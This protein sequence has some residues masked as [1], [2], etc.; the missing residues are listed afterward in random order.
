MCT[1]LRAGS[2]SIFP[3]SNFYL[4]PLSFYT[5]AQIV[6]A[7]RGE[8]QPAAIRNLIELISEAERTYPSDEQRPFNVTMRI[9][10]RFVRT[11]GQEA[12][13]VR[14][15]RDPEAPAVQLREEDIRQAYP[16]DYG[17]L[18]ERLKQ[19]YSDFL[20]NQRYHEIRQRLEHD[21]RLCRIRY[22]DPANPGRSA[23]KRYYSP[24]IIA[25]FDPHYTRR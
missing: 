18:T 4:M 6:E 2:A 5:P 16:W 22:L 1:L 15:V 20:Q 7:L 9:D 14:V 17:E 24:N 3:D 21:D 23:W 10:V 12:V 25:E 13:P 11:P 8:R 19:R